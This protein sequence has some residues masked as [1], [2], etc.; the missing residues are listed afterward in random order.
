MQGV[1]NPVVPN[2]KAPFRAM[3]T[4]AVYEAGL[5]PRPSNDDPVYDCAVAGF[6]C[7]TQHEPT[8]RI[9]T[10]KLPE[11]QMVEMSNF[12]CN[13]EILLCNYLLQGGTSESSVSPSLHLLQ[14]TSMVYTAWR[15]M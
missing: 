4:N 1:L 14:W 5:A 7:L 12:I 10:Q 9:L 13:N 15:S 2:Q 11:D 8:M 6:A 3:L